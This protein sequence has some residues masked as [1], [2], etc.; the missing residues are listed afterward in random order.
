MLPTSA[1]ESGYPHAQSIVRTTTSY[2]VKGNQKLREET[3]EWISSLSVE[4]AGA[5]R[6]GELVRGHWDIEN[7]SHRQRDVLWG[8]DRQRMKNHTR[9]HVLATLRQIGLHIN[10]KQQ[11]ERKQPGLTHGNYKKE[12]RRFGF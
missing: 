6:F 4:E 10:R 2:W 9:A 5:Q 7:R 8:E 1:E 12:D 3:R 11:H